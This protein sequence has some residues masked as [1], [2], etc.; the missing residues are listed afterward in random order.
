MYSCHF[1]LECYNLF[2]GAKLRIR[3]FFFICVVT[4][5]VKAID[6]SCSR[7]AADCNLELP[8]AMVSKHND[9]FCSTLYS[10]VSQ[11]YRLVSFGYPI[12]VLS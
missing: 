9:S 1:I 10:L 4:L 2:S 3:S 11:R 7:H 5:E 6:Q 12:Y 8:P